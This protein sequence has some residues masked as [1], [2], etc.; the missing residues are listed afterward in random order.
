MEIECYKSCWEQPKQKPLKM[1]TYIIYLGLGMG[2]L[3]QHRLGGPM[4]QG[5]ESLK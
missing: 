4:T 3:S 1:H 5:M 2:S